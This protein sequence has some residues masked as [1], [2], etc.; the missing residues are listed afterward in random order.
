MTNTETFK[1]KTDFSIIII[2][3]NQSRQTIKLV[4][5]IVKNDSQVPIVIFDNY[6]DDV[7]SLKELNDYQNVQL[8]YGEKNV[9]YG[10]GINEA[11]RIA[12][13]HEIPFLV[14]LNHDISYDHAVLQK[15]LKGM[16]ANDNLAVAGPL[17]LEKKNDEEIIYSGGRNIN[18]YLN[19]RIEFNSNQNNEEWL[20]VDYV[21]GTFFMVRTSVIEKNFLDTNYF[22]G[23]EVADF[24]AGLKKTYKIQINTHCQI[25]HKLNNRDPLEQSYFKAYYNLRS[26]FI[27]TRKYNGIRSRI[28][29]VFKGLRMAMG[30]FVRLKISLFYIYNIAILDGLLGRFGNANNKILRCIKT[31]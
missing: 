24:C 17:L 3:W 4:Q 27:Y 21:P 19:T 12:K 15:L 10:Q 31:N 30:S 5:S 25:A 1:T 6:S 29:W 26:R 2:N 8:I 28:K 9:G 11:Y 23:G 14:L 7:I 16:K 22:F 20:D 13:L 18:K